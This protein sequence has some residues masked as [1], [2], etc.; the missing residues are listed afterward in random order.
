MRE[1]LLAVE[2]QP[3]DGCPSGGGWRVVPDDAVTTR[4]SNGEP[5]SW[6]RDDSWNLDAYGKNLK[7]RNLHFRKLAPGDVDANVTFASQVQVKQVIF[8][9][10]H[11]A[12]DDMPAPS[13]LGNHLKTLRHFCVFAATRRQSLYQGFADTKT[14]L[15]FIR[16]EG[17]E[18]HS[19]KLHG[20]LVHLHRLGP[21]ATGVDIPLRKLHAPMMERVRER[22]DSAQH[23]VIPT[24]IYQHFLATCDN[25]LEMAE[26]ATDDLIREVYRIYDGEGLS[27]KPSPKLL[28][29]LDCF[30]LEFHAQGIGKL[31]TEIL[32]LCQILILTFTGMR[33][34]EVRSLPFDCLKVARQDGV[35]HYTVEGITTKLSGGRAKRACWVTS[36]IATRAIRLAQRLS[37]EAHRRFG[38]G[39][40][41]TSSDGTHFLFCGTGLGNSTYKLGRGSQEK[42]LDKLCERAFLPISEEDLAELKR[43]DPFRDWE[44]E[45]EFALGSRWPFTR[46]QLRR[47]NLIVVPSK[48]QRVVKAQERRVETLRA[49]APDSVE[50]RMEAATLENLLAAQEKITKRSQT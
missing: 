24:R 31:V 34:A 9:L 6:F 23:P 14:I 25:Q 3:I 38:R 18:L 28:L 26:A 10:M 39:D 40:Y 12:S 50:Y 43:I 32:V 45:P 4:D 15:A 19:L 21:A 29:M 17:T 46:H 49:N 20:V 7:V 8:L 36:H 44:S 47:T 11:H 27:A 1:N 30:G 16:Q 48:L 5:R 42:R 13:T 37:G 35:R 2:T 22:G 33:S 41:A